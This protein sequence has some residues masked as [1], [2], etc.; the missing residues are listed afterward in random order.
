MKKIL[1]I[2]LLV[3]T[4][5]A[6]S[7]FNN[8]VEAQKIAVVDSEALLAASPQMKRAKSQLE[9]LQ[10]QYTKR[11]ETKYQK[12]QKKYADGVK[13]AQ[14]GKLTKPQENALMQ[15]IQKMQDDIAKSE[16]SMQK[17]LLNKEKQ[18]VDPIFKKIKNTI[19]QVA[20]AKG[21][22][23][24]FNK[25]SMIYYPPGDDITKAVKAKLGYK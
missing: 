18:L 21:Y 2:G 3:A 13:S 20:K 24:V 16:R 14:E 9:A 23:Y 6:V 17:Q 11:L 8:D 7:A 15:Q 10:K 19:T 12:M 1:Q 4:M 22:R 25:N 5:I